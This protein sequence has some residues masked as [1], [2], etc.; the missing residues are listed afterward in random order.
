MN[1]TLVCV[2]IKADIYLILIYFLITLNIVIM[3]K[4]EMLKMLAN[5]I[6]VHME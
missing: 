3:I 6:C 2:I 5:F 4:I 1:R